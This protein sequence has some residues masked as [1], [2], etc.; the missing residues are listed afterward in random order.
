MTAMTRWLWGKLFRGN[1]KR[2]FS[3][4]QI[5]LTTRCPL[6]CKMCLRDAATQWHTRDMSMDDFMKVVPYLQE[7]ESAVLEGWGEPLIYR[8]LTR[9]VRLVKET[10]CR[11]G[12]VTSGWGLD[13]DRILE[14]VTAGIDFIG[15]S[16][17]GA[18]PETHNV[19]RANS[20]LH[21]ILRSI[22]TLQELKARKKLDAPKLHIV[23]LML[24]DNIAE[25]P[26]LVD[27]AKE[28]SLDEIVVINLIQVSNAWQEAQRLFTCGEE[29]GHALLREAASKARAWKIHLRLAPLSPGEVGVCAENPLRNLY[30]S[31]DGHV[32]PC[33][34]L[35]PPIPSPFKRLFCGT[36]HAVP[37]VSFGN[38]FQEPF[39]NIWNSAPY[40][41]FR[42]DFRERQ[43]GF[44]AKY[45]PLPS[46]PERIMK[47]AAIALPPPPEP[48][49]TCHKI[50]G[51]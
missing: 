11:A 5:E 3:V 38:I 48:C 4:W 19:I 6:R 49:R 47:A 45:P 17:S 51:L 26:L 37:K 36:E 27:Y 46:D 1:R 40:A 22:Q 35:Y 28:L 29:E 43:K 31:A 33:V 18:T 10:R 34:Y 15:F 13:D 41:A 44:A 8:D 24:R 42:N 2:R 50:L 14:L 25:L 23:F 7:V 39:E 30:I 12:F 20:N 16:V 32:S 9:V 21:Q